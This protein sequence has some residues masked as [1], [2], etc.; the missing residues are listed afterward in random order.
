MC[1]AFAVHIFLRFLIY[2]TMKQKDNLKIITQYLPFSLRA[3]AD[4][5]PDNLQEIRLRINKPVALYTPDK[6]FFIEYNFNL[7]DKL[8][9]NH[10]KIVRKELNE[11]FSA[12]CGYSVYSKQNEIIN[13]FITLKGGNRAGIC[14][15]AVIQDG[16]II[17]IRD[18]TSVNIRLCCERIGCGDRLRGIIENPLGG[19]LLCGVPCSGKTTV[20]RDLARQLSYKYRT[21]L[22]DSRGELAAVYA[23]VP[24][25]DVGLCDI[26]DSYSKRDGFS[27]AV[28]CLSPEIIFC[29]EIGGEDDAKSI[30]N[31]RKSGVSVIAAAH[32]SDKF[33]LLEK[34]YLRAL[35]KTRCFG[36]VV[37]LGSGRSVGAVEEI[38]KCDE[39][40]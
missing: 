24:Q 13:G 36:T 35:I 3:S 17:N 4:N 37:F 28:R 5:I 40:L 20:L 27:H 39:L 19:V 21:A 32:C 10:I 12:M 1:T 16:R 30:L 7:T 33:E 9:D 31:A 2:L 26:L 15:T 18:I 34:P 8:S 14:G 23:G 6:I 29:D 22:I 25:N 38:I 11:V